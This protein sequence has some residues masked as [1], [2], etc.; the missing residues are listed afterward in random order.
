MMKFFWGVMYIGLMICFLI[1]NSNANGQENNFPRLTEYSTG[2]DDSTVIATRLIN[3]ANG[4][5]RQNPGSARKLLY[6]AIKFAANDSESLVRYNAWHALGMLEFY[7][8]SY[9]ESLK[10]Y[11]RALRLSETNNDTVAM[12]NTKN[13]LGIL[14]EKSGNLTDA[15][16]YYS[17]ALELSKRLGDQDGIAASLNNLGNAYQGIDSLDLA[18]DYYRQVEQIRAQQHDSLYLAFC[19][20][21]IGNLLLKQEKKDEAGT[22]YG[23]GMSI[24]KKLNDTA[25]LARSYMNLAILSRE[26][27]KYPYAFSMLDTGINL[28]RNANEKALMALF[29]ETYS[30]TY[31]LAGN[32]KK[33]Y[34]WRL[35]YETA[36]NSYLSD[37]NMKLINEMQIRFESESKARQ[38]ELLKKERELKELH[39]RQQSAKLDRSRIQMFILVIVV[40]L[41]LVSSYLFFRSYRMGQKAR[42]H[43]EKIRHRE[44]QIRTI[45][46]TQE[47]ERNR[48]ARDLHDGLGQYL[49]ALKLSI[50][51]FSSQAGLPEKK[52]SESFDKI[53]LL[54]NDIYQELRNITFNIMP[55]VLLNK[56]LVPAMEELV[57]KMHDTVNINI[58][59]FAYGVKKR[60]PSEKEIA[61]YRII[62]ELLNNAIKHAQ[63]R[64]ATITFTEHEKEFNVMVETS[65]QEFSSETASKHKGNGW[66]N[67]L[68]RLEMLNG[69]IETDTSPVRNT[70]IFIIDIPVN[71]E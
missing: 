25:S 4:I 18:L 50:I 32:Y 19:Y 69:R 53:M 34:E 7:S 44:D 48:F 62:Q 21:N 52:Q 23:K 20:G 13:N 38:I 12:S 68:S 51:N 59:L 14:L 41:T 43:K 15:M 49:T 27:G 8:G 70:T 9:S 61:L 47:N 39:I 28:A 36:H 66:K 60:L 22:Y 65:G 71:H 30:E 17:Q 63:S 45:I 16:K 64:E 2:S 58:S 5:M 24:F 10:Y 55:Q 56:G 1:P 35:E 3:R 40:V 6:D 54:F 46:Q 57:R 26:Q 42:F 11:L 67:I 37:E 31:A 29:G 33:A